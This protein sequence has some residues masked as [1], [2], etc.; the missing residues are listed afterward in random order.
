MTALQFDTTQLIKRR[1]A[2]VLLLNVILGFIVEFSLI[3][4]SQKQGT[5]TQIHMKRILLRNFD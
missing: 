3:P 1:E 4:G 2:P 5:S